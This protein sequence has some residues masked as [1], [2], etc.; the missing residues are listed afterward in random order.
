MA[1]YKRPP[2]KGA[3]VQLA[4]RGYALRTI[5]EAGTVM[6]AICQDCPNVRHFPPLEIRARFKPLLDDDVTRFADKLRCR[7]C[8]SADVFL[9]IHTGL[10]WNV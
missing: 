4:L 2:A 6:K 5:A 8:G 10:G 9:T 7:Q 1:H 3:T